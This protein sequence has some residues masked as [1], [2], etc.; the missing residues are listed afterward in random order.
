MVC[1]EPRLYSFSWKLLYRTVESLATALCSELSL[2]PFIVLI[3]SSSETSASGSKK[4]SARPDSNVAGEVQASYKG[5]VNGAA[6]LSQSVTFEVGDFDEVL[7]RL[8]SLRKAIE[9]DKP[10]KQLLFEKFIYCTYLTNSLLRYMEG[11][12]SV[13]AIT[14]VRDEEKRPTYE[15]KFS[16]ID[17]TLLIPSKTSFAVT[18]EAGSGK[19]SL[20][21]ILTALACQTDRRC[22][23]FPCSKIESDGDALKTC[24]GEH[25]VSVNAISRETDLDRILQGVSVVI[26]D[27]CDESATFSSKKL[28]RELQRL[29]FRAP[30]SLSFDAAEPCGVYIPLGHLNPKTHSA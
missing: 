14:R 6:D 27:G 29:H 11:R 24:I 25:L 1:A 19:T 9:E 18:G 28:S 15:L 12:T 4:R 30:C 21:R 8:Q 2:T 20:S 23:F 22:V 16:E 13:S 3:P 7:N 26:L 10:K 17:P 5:S